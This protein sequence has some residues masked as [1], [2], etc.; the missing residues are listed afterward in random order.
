MRT[1]LISALVALGFLALAAPIGGATACPSEDKAS[2]TPQVA[3]KKV[4]KKKVVKKA[5]ARKAPFK[6]G[7][8]KPAT[9]KTIAKK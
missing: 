5:Q 9:T 3:T 7:V 2:A 4:T 1:K 8:A 6:K